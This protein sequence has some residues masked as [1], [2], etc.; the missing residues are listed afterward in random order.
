MIESIQDEEPIL[1]Y[2]TNQFW[3]TNG[4]GYPRRSRINCATMR[5]SQHVGFECDYAF[6]ERD[7]RRMVRMM[8]DGEALFMKTCWQ[9]EE[10]YAHIVAPIAHLRTDAI[11]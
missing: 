1:G 5:T 2:E 10:N 4:R 8:L 6:T 3:S 11:T 7:L 9:V